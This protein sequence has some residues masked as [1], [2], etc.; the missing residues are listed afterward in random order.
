VTLDDWAARAER[1]APWVRRAAWV[2]LAG[3]LVAFL[4]RGA[5]QPADPHLVGAGRQPLA[6]FAEAAFEV[7]TP[8][9]R[10][11]DWCALLAATEAARE[12]GL[13]E[14]EDLR[15]YDGM[16][17]RF[18]QPTDARFY[19]FHTLIPLSIAFFDESGAYVS[20]ADM[21]VC[22]ADDPGSCPTYPAAERYVHALEVPKGALGRLG[23]GP[24]TTIAVTDGEC[25]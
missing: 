17:F 15:G 25:S 18:D 5:D 19:M 24:G 6:G 7:R 12:Q 21:P 22:T 23:I 2:V 20:Q 8:E 10:V 4:L 3:A 11:L 14:Q 16:L 1:H 13:M 9:G